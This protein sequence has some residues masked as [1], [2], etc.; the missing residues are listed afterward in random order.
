MLNKK[1]IIIVGILLTLTSIICIY[2]YSILNDSNILV[3][4]RRLCGEQISILK[5][6]KGGRLYSPKEVNEL[7]ICNKDNKDSYFMVFLSSWNSSS[8]Y[9]YDTEDDE[10]RIFKRNVVYQFIP[11]KHKLFCLDLDK[12]TDRIILIKNIK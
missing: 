4:N 5:N 6:K 7:L 8:F 10:Y 3:D 12:N 1:W 2:Q 9:I 11:K